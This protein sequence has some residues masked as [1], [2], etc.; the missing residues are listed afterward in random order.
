MAATAGALVE[1]GLQVLQ[2]LVLSFW[3]NHTNA[4]RQ[5][6]AAGRG[7]LA[8]HDTRFYLSLYFILGLSSVGVVLGRSA[9]LV[10]G[11]ITASR[12]LHKQLLAKIVRLPMSFFDAQPTGLL[13]AWS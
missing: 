5:A 4:V 9:V 3:A 13:S 8:S 12:K 11:S 7:T 10:W 2:N 1:R 6:S